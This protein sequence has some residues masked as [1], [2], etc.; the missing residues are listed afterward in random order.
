MVSGGYA[1]N[2]VRVLTVIWTL[3]CR[4]ID[5]ALVTTSDYNHGGP[6]RYTSVG[7]GGGECG[8][9]ADGGAV[10]D[11]LSLGFFFDIDAKLI[12]IQRRHQQC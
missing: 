8:S 11:P 12:L 4:N 2:A 9:N 5:P 6:S 7:D 10:V 1:D 3:L